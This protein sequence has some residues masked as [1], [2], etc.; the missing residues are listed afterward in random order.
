MANI[1]EKDISILAGN[2]NFGSSYLITTVLLLLC[3]HHTSLFYE[4]NVLFL[5][6]LVFHECAMSSFLLHKTQ[7]SELEDSIWKLYL[8][9]NWPV[10]ITFEIT[11]NSQELNK[12]L[13]LCND[14]YS[15]KIMSNFITN[16]ILNFYFQMR[17][18]TSDHCGLFSFK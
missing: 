14:K 10:E 6:A 15:E 8:L 7:S 4:K 11:W 13:I 9:I 18:I 12:V 16:K 17:F 3:T 1:W 2:L 5:R